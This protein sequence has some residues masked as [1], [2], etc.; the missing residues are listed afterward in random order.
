MSFKIQGPLEDFNSGLKILVFGGTGGLGRA[1]SRTLAASGANVT[2]VGQ[3]FRDEGTENISFVKADLS[4]IE[5]SIKVAQSLDV[6][7]T[8]VLLF[9]TGIFASKQKEVTKEGLEKDLAVS[10]LNRLVIIDYLAP[11]LESHSNFKPRV[12]IMGY[13]GIGQLGTIDDL[14]QEKSYQ[15]YKAHMNTVA[16]NEALV[17]YGKKQFPNANFYGLNPGLVK[18]SIRSNLFGNGWVGSAIEYLI[19]WLT[20]TADDYA[21]T[22]SPV[23]VSPILDDHNGSLIDRKG[24]QLNASKGLDEEYALRFIEASKELLKSKG[25]I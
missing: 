10:Y 23:F 25:L 3:T 14:N 13:P 4:S 2:V 5:D 9:T 19:S 12:F 17:L 7:G 6:S 20:P 15:F 21:K 22:I 18:T 8:S 16:G 1:I 24:A 11:K